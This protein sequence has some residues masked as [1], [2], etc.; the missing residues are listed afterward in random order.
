VNLEYVPEVSLGPGTTIAYDVRSVF[1]TMRTHDI[2]YMLGVGASFACVFPRMFGKHVWINPDGLEWKR[3][4]WGVLGRFYLRLM[5]WT[6]STF[7]NLLIADAHALQLYLE[8][9]Y[10][11]RVRTTCIPYGATIPKVSQFR[12]E[13]LPGGLSPDSYNLLVARLE[14]ENQILEIIRGY[15]VSDMSR[16]LVIVGN[17]ERQLAYARSLLQFASSRIHFAGAVYDRE[18]LIALR[19]LARYAFH[20]HTV[21]GTNPSL[22]EALACGNLIIAHSNPFNR[23]VGGDLMQYFTDSQEIPAALE[24]F[25]RMSL[26]ERDR[27]RAF[28]RARIREHYSWEKV[29]RTYVALAHQTMAGSPQQFAVGSTGKVP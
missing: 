3:S 12:P 18:V 24:R 26:K 19:G 7:A 5:E 29:T 6:A 9:T 17:L 21:G 16:P 14:P 15:L 11:E 23:E 27:I 4:K 13:L 25:E 28:S 1:A 8:S 20:G 2:V 10:G 22:L